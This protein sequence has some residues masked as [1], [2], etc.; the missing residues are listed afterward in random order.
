MY[1]KVRLEVIGKGASDCDGYTSNTEEATF[2]VRNSHLI[3][4]IVGHSVE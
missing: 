4:R 2:I 1:V 3:N